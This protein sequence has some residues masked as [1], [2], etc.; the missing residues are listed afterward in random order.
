MSSSAVPDDE[1]FVMEACSIEVWR[2]GD[3]IRI[4]IRSQDSVG[5]C[6]EL[7]IDEARDFANRVSASASNFVRAIRDEPQA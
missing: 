2:W 5:K 7:P 1:G 3:A 6:I 4:A